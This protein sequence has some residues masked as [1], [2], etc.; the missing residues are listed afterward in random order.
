MIEHYTPVSYAKHLASYIKDPS[1][2]RAH[3]KTEYGRAP[4]VDV[5][6]KIQAELRKTDRVDGYQLCES[7]YRPL[8]KCGH[9]ETEDNIVL[10][11]NGIDKCRQ[12]EEA[13]AKALA[14]REQKRRAILK[15]KMEQERAIREA[16][17]SV[18]IQKTLQ[19]ILE[20]PPSD[21]PRLGTEVIRRVA[22]MFKV[23]PQDN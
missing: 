17:E 12:C 15:Q 7:R 1:T 5:I 23:T 3:V 21:R 19:V 18:K 14:E 10:S 16:L 6:R 13:K 9:P 4:S 20:T 2:I 8:F 22:E 11:M